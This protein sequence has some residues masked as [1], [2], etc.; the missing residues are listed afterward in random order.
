[1]SIEGNVHLECKGRVCIY[2]DDDTLCTKSSLISIVLIFSCYLNFFFILFQF[3]CL[4]Q[5]ASGKIGTLKLL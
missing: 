3:F 2:D 4:N 5:I 1:M